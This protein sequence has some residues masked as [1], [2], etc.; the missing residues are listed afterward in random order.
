MFF[1]FEYFLPKDYL[2]FSKELLFNSDNFNCGISALKRTIYSRAYYST[3]LHI[4]EWLILN[5][6][7]KSGGNDHGDIPDFIRLKGP[8]DCAKNSELA[9]NLEY[10]KN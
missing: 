3:F 8:F 2:D 6:G 5:A 9:T 4:R 7:Y 10:L 1:E